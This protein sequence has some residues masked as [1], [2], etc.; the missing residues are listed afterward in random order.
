MRVLTVLQPWASLIVLR[1][2]QYE[3]RYWRTSYRGPVA[4]H[5]GHSLTDQA[6]HLARTEYAHVLTVKYKDKSY[7]W[8]PTGAIL[9][10]MDLADCVRDGD[11]YAF[12]LR[13]LLRF[14]QPVKHGGSKGF[15]DINESELPELLE[16]K[17]THGVA[18]ERSQLGKGSTVS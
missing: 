2:K 9:G 18:D 7:L 13:Y 17:H 5:A 1:A 11:G 15:W 4:I 16:F 14:K 8:L 6:R 10:V 3:Y 12:D